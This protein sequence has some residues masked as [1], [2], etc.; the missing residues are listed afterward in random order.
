MVGLRREDKRLYHLIKQTA[1][2]LVI[3][4]VINLKLAI[5]EILFVFS[6]LVFYFLILWL[7]GVGLY[8]GITKWTT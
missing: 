8:L 1:M 6:F 4:V 3:F 7:G 2:K 5:L